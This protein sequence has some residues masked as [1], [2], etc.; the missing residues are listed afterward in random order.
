MKP[1]FP[2]VIDGALHEDAVL[3][4]SVQSG[5]FS[6]GE[7]LFETLS[8]VR[9]AAD[10]LTLHLA[11]LNAAAEV[12]EFRPVPTRDQ[13]RTDLRMLVKAAAVD[14]L[15]VRL[16]LFRGLDRLHR[17]VSA[18]AMP[19]DVG[20]SVKIGRCDPRLDGPR[21]LA[22]FKTLNYLSSRRAHE[23]GA[24][25]GLDEVIF[26]R[27]D[28]LVLEGTRS[29]VFA[30]IDGELRTAPLDGQILP[31]VTRQILIEEARGIGLAVSEVH[32]HWRDLAR[33]SEAFISASVRGLR[34]ILSFEGSPVGS[35]G[36]SVVPALVERYRIRRARDAEA[37]G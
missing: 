33:A 9:G 30:M 3:G 36:A 11:R 18:T 4:V 27:P 22:A 28:G 20:S 37:L 2:A 6:S 25:V 10:F 32:F 17:V 26:T 34:P 35:P 23:W 19:K 7:G 21:A 24:R 5:G 12:L 14:S 1:E 29:S 15:A 8:V 16:V 13:W 31:G